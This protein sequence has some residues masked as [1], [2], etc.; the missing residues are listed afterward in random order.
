MTVTILR[1]DAAKTDPAREALREVIAAEKAA[2]DAIER[3]KLAI[4]RAEA[5]LA[6]C[7]ADLEAATAA[8]E[9]AK[10]EDATNAAAA[11]SNAAVVGA[12]TAARKARARALEYEDSRDVAVAALSLANAALSDLEEAARVKRNAVD[13]AIN[14]VL[15]PVVE[16]CLAA[17][18]DYKR[19]LAICMAVVG[20]V[21]DDAT[22]RGAPLA[23]LRE[24][25][26]RIAALSAID[27]AGD[28][29]PAAL[30]AWRHAL[31]ALKQDASAV[32]PTSP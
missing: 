11:I 24:R 22:R 26:E 15:T 12:P 1:K 23:G 31:S 27:V 28:A 7:E 29:L 25:H 8:V 19:R 6:K 4:G 14:C 9:S 32:L 21:L 17:A 18:E 3:Q 20:S 30:S 13:V 16:G 5:H 2:H 10:H